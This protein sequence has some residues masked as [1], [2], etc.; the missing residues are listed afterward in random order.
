MLEVKFIIK[1]L[2]RGTVNDA[3]ELRRNDRSFKKL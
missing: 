3:E 2:K 1:N